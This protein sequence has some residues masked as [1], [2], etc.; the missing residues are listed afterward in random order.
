MNMLEISERLTE[1]L[2]SLASEQLMEKTCYEDAR[3][4]V[5]LFRMIMSQQHG[6]KIAA[7][8]VSIVGNIS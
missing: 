6:N 3:R 2:L 1:D 7:I 8:N 4:T 5:I